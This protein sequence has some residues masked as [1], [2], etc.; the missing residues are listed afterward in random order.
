MSKKTPNSRNLEQGKDTKKDKPQ[1]KK[2]SDAID[3]A[4]T[5]EPIAEQAILSKQ[6]EAHRKNRIKYK[7]DVTEIIPPPQIAWSLANTKKSGN[8]ILGTLGNF[9]A[10]IGKAKSRKSFYVNIAVSTA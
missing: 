1:A 4:M 9:S 8:E 7:I 3:N 2:L 5:I 10:I 6:I